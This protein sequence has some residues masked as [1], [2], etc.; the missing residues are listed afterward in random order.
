M[1][2][3]SRSW[4]I[5]PFDWRRITCEISSLMHIPLGNE[6]GRQLISTSNLPY[7]F[8]MPAWEACWPGRRVGTHDFFE[9][10]WNPA[11]LRQRNIGRNGVFFACPVHLERSIRLFVAWQVEVALA[12]VAPE[13]R[14]IHTFASTFERSDDLGRV[15][16]QM[17]SA[18]ETIEARGGD[19][20]SCHGDAFVCRRTVAPPFEINRR[21]RSCSVRPALSN[22]HNPSMPASS[23]KRVVRNHILSS[24]PSIVY[25]HQ[26]R[27][28]KG[29][30]LPGMPAMP[31]VD[32]T[33]ASSTQRGPWPL[34]LPNKITL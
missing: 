13:R 19:L 29:T 17:H 21:P 16:F 31:E 1:D 2:V 15:D 5:R 33:R 30:N 12:A 23:A 28:A 14:R 34:P 26:S 11:H 8:R 22:T 24:E 32:S 10:P 20:A 4:E 27:P 7:S 9:V 6:V 18:S 25:L 3:V